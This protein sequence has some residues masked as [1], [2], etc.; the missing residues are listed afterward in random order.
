ML[1]AAHSVKNV[2]TRIHTD[3]HTQASLGK[4]G[5]IKVGK[6]LLYWCNFIRG[7]LVP[8]IGWGVPKKR[9]REREM[10]E[11]E[12]GREWTREWAKTEKVWRKT[13]TA[14]AKADKQSCSLLRDVD[15]SVYSADGPTSSDHKAKPKLVW[16]TNE[17]ISVHCICWASNPVW[18]A[19][20]FWN[21][22]I[23]TQSFVIGKEGLGDV[24][25]EGGG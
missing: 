19:D 3:A 18:N 23:P 17:L 4:Y 1:Q 25:W 9:A 12:R 22:K 20:C 11:K 8:E 21:Q 24:C 5:Q 14:A 16:E 2:L 6:H 15:M 7:D 13:I 10:S